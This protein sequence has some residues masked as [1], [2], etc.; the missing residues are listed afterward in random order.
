VFV[1][2]AKL[3]ADVRGDARLDPAGAQRNQPKTD[4]QHLL[5]TE[6]DAPGGVH[7]GESEMAQAVNDR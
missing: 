7:E 4:G 2:F 6:A 5:L 3:I 1:R